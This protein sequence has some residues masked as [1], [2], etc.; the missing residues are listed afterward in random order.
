MGKNIMMVTITV[1]SIMPTIT[2][3]R[4]TGIIMPTIIRKLITL[5]MRKSRKLPP[6]QKK[7][8]KPRLGKLRPRKTSLVR[9]DF[10]SDVFN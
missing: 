4:I 7:K 3:K 1:T 10:N 6:K 9:R 2:K 8:R 5:T